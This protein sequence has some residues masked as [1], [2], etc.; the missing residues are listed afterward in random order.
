MHN[1]KNVRGVEIDLE[2]FKFAKFKKANPP[3][4]RGTFNLDKGEKW[5]KEIEKIFSTLACTER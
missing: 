2:Y 4:F 1:G 3:P 5:I